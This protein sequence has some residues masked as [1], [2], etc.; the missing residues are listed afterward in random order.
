MKKEAMELEVSNKEKSSEKKK[1]CFWCL[2]KKKQFSWWEEPDV[3][4]KADTYYFRQD[5]AYARTEKKFY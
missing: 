3:I 4:N 1:K 5:P 2:K